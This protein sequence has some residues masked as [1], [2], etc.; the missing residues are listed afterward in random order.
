[1]F[2]FFLWNILITPVEE[3]NNRLIYS[4]HARVGLRN[5][6]LYF[7]YNLNPIFSNQLSTQLNLV[8]MG[9]SVSLF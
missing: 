8:Q 9:L 7:S 3:A 4:V 5:W 1:M 6:A 2:Q